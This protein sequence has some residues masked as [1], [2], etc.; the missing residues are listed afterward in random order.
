MGNTVSFFRCFLPYFSDF[1]GRL[2]PMFFST[3]SSAGMFFRDLLVLSRIYQGLLAF[4]GIYWNGTKKVGTRQ[5]RVGKGWD[6]VENVGNSTNSQDFFGFL[7]KVEGFCEF[8]LDRRRNRPILQNH[9]LSFP[10][11]KQKYLLMWRTAHTHPWVSGVFC[12]T[13]RD[14]YEGTLPTYS[15][16]AH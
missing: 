6:N 15:P 4:S 13:S 8:T 16:G 14:C 5:E 12:A 9:K 2:Y 11:P 3:F 10:V 1:L 7:V